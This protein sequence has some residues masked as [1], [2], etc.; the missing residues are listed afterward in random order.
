MHGLVPEAIHLVGRGMVVGWVGVDLMVAHVPA[1]VVGGWVSH[2]AWL[3]HAAGLS[4]LVLLGHHVHFWH[5]VWV[6]GDS[7]GVVILI[8]IIYGICKFWRRNYEILMKK[9][10]ENIFNSFVFLSFF[11][12]R[13]KIRRMKIFVKV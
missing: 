5:W 12:L 3:S 13:C 7:L 8:F 9:R 1:S 11:I 2:A 4:H 6:V 10:R